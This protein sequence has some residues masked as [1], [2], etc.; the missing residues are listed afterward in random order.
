MIKTITTASLLVVGGMGKKT[1]RKSTNSLVGQGVVDFLDAVEEM[2][3]MVGEDL[4]GEGQEGYGLQGEGQEGAV[5]KEE[6]QEG[7]GLKGEG[8]ER[9]VLKGEGQELGQ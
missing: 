4:E 7:E 1:S 9:E 3:C 8:Q 5:L 2:V 6:G